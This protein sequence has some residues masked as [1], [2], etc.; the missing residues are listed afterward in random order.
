VQQRRVGDEVV[1]DL[2]EIRGSR[3]ID[4]WSGGHLGV[5]RQKAR[6]V[7]QFLSIDIGLGDLLKPHDEKLQRLPMIDREQFL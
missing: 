2:A 3:Q 1:E 5:V 4:V 7:K 6:V